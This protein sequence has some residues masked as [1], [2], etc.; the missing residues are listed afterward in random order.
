VSAVV[1]LAPGDAVRVQ[2]MERP[3]SHSAIP[4]D[5]P[6]RRAQ[7]GVECH[8]YSYSWWTVTSSG[9][10]ASAMH[11][12]HNVRVT[13]QNREVLVLHHRRQGRS[14]RHRWPVRWLRR[15]QGE[16]TKGSACVKPSHRLVVEGDTHARASRFYSIESH[17]FMFILAKLTLSFCRM[18]RIIEAR[19]HILAFWCPTSYVG[20]LGTEWQK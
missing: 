3:H 7:A 16:D 10:P 5:A 9:T 14:L 1:C 12:W 20:I 11:W 8:G 6:R 17:G 19:L 4:V 18:A 15:Q 2:A 13:K